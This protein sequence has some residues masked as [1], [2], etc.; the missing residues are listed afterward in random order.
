VEVSPRVEAVV[1]HALEK[2]VEAR[3]S[4]VEE[5]LTELRAAVEA[6]GVTMQAGRETIGGDFGATLFE[7]SSLDT[8]PPQKTSDVPA[9]STAGKI[10][11]PVLSPAEQERLAASRAQ[12]EFEQQERDRIAREELERE[13]TARRQAAQET[14]RKR[15]EDE[16][17]VNR[18]KAEREE[19]ERQQR[20]QIERV[21]R[22]ARELEERLAKLSTSMPPAASTVDPESTQMHQGLRTAQISRHSIPGVTPAISDSATGVSVPIPARQPKSKLPMVVGGVLLVLLLLGGGTAAFF[23]FK[24]TTNGGNN[25]TNPTP[26]PTVGPEIIRTDMVEIPGGAFQ[27]GRDDGLAREAPAHEEKVDSFLMDKTEVTNAEYA[28]FIRD[29]PNY[30]PPQDWNNATKPPHGTDQWPVVFVSIKDVD[31]FAKWRSK[32]DNLNYRLPTEQEWE[33]AAR[34][35]SRSDLYPWGN[36]WQ[37]K[38]AWL[39]E[40]SPTKVGSFPGGNNTWGVADLLGNAWEWTSSKVSAYPGNPTTIPTATKDWVIIRGAGYNINP[41]DRDTPATSCLRSWVSPE[42]KDP[43]I[44]FRLVRSPQ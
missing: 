18:E 24:P 30:A 3:T 17:R 26:T 44:G 41:S 40:T 4:T 21:E 37:D 23:M 9:G 38:Q 16:E 1:F 35:G 15:K 42:T 2:E 29:T 6:D 8:A 25:I 14:E 32:R 39:K 5:F 28:E 12:H 22:Q 20:E 34:N 13:A 19:R 43:R 27:M 10:S 36:Q 7:P 11:S 33:Y 31:A